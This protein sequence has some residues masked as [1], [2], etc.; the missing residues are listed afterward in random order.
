MGGAPWP[1]ISQEHGLEVLPV[2]CSLL[3]LFVDF[4]V[5]SR[6]IERFYGSS[7][8]RPHG[9]HSICLGPKVVLREPFAP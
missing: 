5:P 9:V 7:G 2:V 4:E 1:F 8:A 3:K 6:C